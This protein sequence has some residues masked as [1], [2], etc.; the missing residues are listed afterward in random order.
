K[1]CEAEKWYVEFKDQ[2]DGIR[3]IPAFISKA[4]SEELGRGVEKLVAYHRSSGGQ[5][6][7]A[8]TR[9]LE[10]LD[11]AT[12]ARL[13]VIGLLDAERAAARKRLVDHLEDFE[14]SLA[15]KGGTEAHVKVVVN[16]LK[17]LIAGC[18]FKHFG[19]IRASKV[20]ALLKD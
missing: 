9:W 6:D 19:D 13:V 16:R 17:R 14:A 20:Q 10:G 2:L 11:E 12:R 3:R 4:A 1:T 7:P 18:G 15:A 5:V 8:L